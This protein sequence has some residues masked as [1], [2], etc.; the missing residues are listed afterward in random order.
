[1]KLVREALSDVMKPVTPEMILP[2]IKRKLEAIPKTVIKEGPGY[3]VYQLKHG[4]DMKS[5]ISRHYGSDDI[6][7]NY[8]FVLDENNDAQLMGLGV[9]VDLQNNVKVF[10]LKGNSVDKEVIA[11]Y[12]D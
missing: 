8:Y 12:S 7:S 5:I 11:K 4:K 3:T 9:E 6:F 10:D 1:M 2:T